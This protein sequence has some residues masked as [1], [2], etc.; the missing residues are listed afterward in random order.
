[1]R[2]PRSH[3]L[4]CLLQHPGP[5]RWRRPPPFTLAPAVVLIS[6][7]PGSM[8]CHPPPPSLAIVPPSRD[9][10]APVYFSHNVRAD[11][12]MTRGDKAVVAPYIPADWRPAAAV[13]SLV[14]G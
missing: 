4:V 12:L 13:G 8:R 1:M 3:P 5:P 11:Y 7:T 14:C 2:R 9:G 10:P 6:Q